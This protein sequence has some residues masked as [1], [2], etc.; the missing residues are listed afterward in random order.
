MV[1]FGSH[2][3]NHQFQPFLSGAYAGVI[4]GW[5]GR[6]ADRVPTFQLW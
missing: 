2:V 5:E 4:V 3:G 6:T 1:T